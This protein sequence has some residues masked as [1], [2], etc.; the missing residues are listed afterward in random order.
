MN[1]ARIFLIFFCVLILSQGLHAQDFGRSNE[2]IQ[3]D[4]E[5]AKMIK[6]I[7]LDKFDV[8]LPEIMREREIDMW[9]HVVREGDLDPLGY[10]FG[11]NEG[12][13]VFT[14]RGGDKIER[15]FFGWNT[16]KVEESGAYDIVIKPEIKTPLEAYPN[17]RIF[18][19]DLYRMGEAEWPGGPKT[20]L[21]FRYPGL[22]EFVAERDPKRI[23]VNYLDELGS[24]IFYEMPRLRPDGISHTDYN[25]L[26]KA[27]GN[28][29]TGRLVSSE[30]LIVDYFA[31]PVPSEFN[32]YKRIR[33]DIDEIQQKALSKVVPGV[34]KLSELG[35]ERSVVD[36]NGRP[37]GG[38]YVIQRG[39]LMIL[40]DGHQSG[41]F[42]MPERWQYGN[43]HEVTDAYA[44]VLEE[45]ETEPP[46]HIKRMW[47]EAMKVRQIIED[48]V[49]VGRTADATYEILKQKVVEAGMINT[50]IQRFDRS[51]FPDKTWVAIDLHAAGSGIYA[52]RIG[53]LGPD[54][55]NA[56]KLP[57]YHHFYMEF[58]IDI[59]M[60]EWGKGESINLRFH[61]G[62][63]T[64]ERGVEYFFPY[65][66]ELQLIR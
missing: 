42:M 13:F 57:L 48:H 51:R 58:F 38:D 66:T 6:Q 47:S 7:L 52:P 49:K 40:N 63:M 12:V 33:A 19:V 22:G 17:I 10:N 60:P 20:E 65:P 53:P 54:W 2:R 37:Q 27:L 3:M 26:V 29:Y 62:V 45:G 18:L 64:T 34:T 59:P 4:E 41:G 8:I 61:D 23:A 14:D 35:E 50:E 9:I 44:Y 36:K 39:D 5:V 28:V 16:D 25:R 32:L 30:Y 31:R 1:K 46:A 55:Q 11:S 56:I 24:A 21:D 43:Y 15:A